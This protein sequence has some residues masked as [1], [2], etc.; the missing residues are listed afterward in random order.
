[1]TEALPGTWEPRVIRKERRL[2]LPGVVLVD[3]GDRVQPS[4]VI[5]RTELVPGAPHLVEVAAELGIPAAQAA[6][7]ILKK[8]GDRVEAGEVIARLEQPLRPTREVRSPTSGLVEFISSVHGRVLIREEM[9]EADPLVM[10]NVARELDIHPY[11]LRWFMRY[12]EGDEVRQGALLAAD[13][14]SASFMNACYSPVTGVIEKIDTRTG[15]VTIRRPYRPTTVEAYIPGTV[16]RAI[17]EWGAVIRGCG[18]LI[19]G[20]FGFGFEVYGP[21][22]PVVSSPDEPLTAD[23]LG[24][25]SEGK[26]VVGGSLVTLDALRKAAELGVRGIVVGGANNH[27]IVTFLGKPL[28]AVTGQEETDLT[29]VLTEGFGAMPMNPAVFR[30]LQ[31]SEGKLA[32][33]DGSTQ[34]RAG[35]VRPELILPVDAPPARETEGTFPRLRVGARVRILRQPHAGATGTVQALPPEPQMLETEML[36]KVAIVRLDDGGEVTVPRANL[37][38][39]EG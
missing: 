15:L 22:L 33:M 12:R 39:M 37:R 1:M 21:L 32:S 5:A 14:G 17:P 25:E 31:Q 35:V 11:R 30:L 18:H 20:A 36:V 7:C 34:L 28:G 2:P 16:E 9:K 38:V 3:E 4:T 27:E 24:P 8:V 26:I 19:H 13:V 23:L 6:S 29:L 10:V